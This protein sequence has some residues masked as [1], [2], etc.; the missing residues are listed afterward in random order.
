MEKNEVKCI[1]YNIGN[2]P[3]DNFFTLYSK[4]S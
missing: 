4:A 1:L 3:T 2:M